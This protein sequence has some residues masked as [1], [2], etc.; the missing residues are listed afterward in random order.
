MIK[1]TYK[2]REPWE[3]YVVT[4]REKTEL[5][6]KCS[7]YSSCAAKAPLIIVPCFRTAG[8]IIFEAVSESRR[9]WFYG[10]NPIKNLR[11]KKNDT[12]QW[13]PLL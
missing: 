11:R 9:C 13:M 5:L 7:P 1:D 12:I 8:Y 10:K 4:D 3:F 6:S 2:L